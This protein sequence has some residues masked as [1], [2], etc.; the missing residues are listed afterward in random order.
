[1]INELNQ[2][3]G[4]MSYDGLISDL[5]PP[6][7]VR[8]R[9]IAK[10][11]EKQTFVRGTIFAKSAGTNKLY[12]LGSVP[13]AG[14][15]LLPDCVLCDDTTVG[16]A[17]DVNVAVY[18]AGCFNPEKTTVKGGYEITETDFDELR[19]RNIVFKAVSN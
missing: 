15:T 17:D 18:T 6:V 2:K 10:S 5:N 19:K 12:V 3:V 9:A 7:E 8:G 13:E 16:T 14:D 1:M 11:T 4:E